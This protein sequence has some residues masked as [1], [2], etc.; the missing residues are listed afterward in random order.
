MCKELAQVLAQIMMKHLKGT[1]DHELLQE[2]WCKIKL[3]A[4]G[5][6]DGH[7]I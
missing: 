7:Q 4:Y 3:V 2:K 1:I 5:D 6:A